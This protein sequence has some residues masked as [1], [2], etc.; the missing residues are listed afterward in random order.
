MSNSDMYDDKTIPLYEQVKISIFNGYI[1]SLDSLNEYQK[2]SYAKTKIE[3]ISNLK[4]LYLLI[5][6]KLKE[7]IVSMENTIFER[8]DLEMKEA[9][10]NL[11]KIGDI[12]ENDIGITKTTYQQ[13]KPEMA[14]K[15]K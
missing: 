14:Y 13:V 6:P 4:S 7:K 12:L 2:R 3:F 11:G 10:D 5:R 1:K 9:I 8:K 15:Y